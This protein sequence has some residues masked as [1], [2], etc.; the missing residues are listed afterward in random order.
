MILSPKTGQIHSPKL[1]TSTAP[2]AK[3]LARKPAERRTCEGGSERLF[4]Q[5]PEQKPAAPLAQE[6]CL[7][8]PLTSPVHLLPSLG[9]SSAARRGPAGTDGGSCQM[10]GGFPAGKLQGGL[11]RPGEGMPMAGQQ[12]RSSQHSLGLVSSPNHAGAGGTE[13]GEKAPRR[14][15][16][17]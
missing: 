5:P 4:V 14:G 12:C 1:P 15:F 2:P 17:H 10:C 3:P 16:S 9:S 7:L 11:R 8:S 6:G 13:E